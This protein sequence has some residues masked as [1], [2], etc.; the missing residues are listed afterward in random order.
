VDEIGIDDANAYTTPDRA[1]VVDD[2]EVTA[3]G[4]KAGKRIGL[5]VSTQATDVPG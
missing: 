1:T 2:S 3:G 5:T 4:S